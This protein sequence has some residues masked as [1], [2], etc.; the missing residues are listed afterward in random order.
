[1]AIA[2]FA[3]LFAL[4]LFS[5]MLLLLE[6]G[7]RLG[8]RRAAADAEGARAGLGAVEGAVFGLMGLLVAFSF[9][10]AAARFDIR[11]RLIV[12][13]ANAIGTAY[14]RLDLL[15][16]GAQPKLRDQFRRYVDSRLEIYRKLPDVSSASEA[17]VRSNAIQGEI[18]TAA[19]EALREAPQAAVLVLPPLNAMIDITTSRTVALQTHPPALIFAML[20]VVS[21]ACSL[22]A[23]HGMAGAR[24]RS[25]VH[26]VVFAAIL[27]LTVYV[28][29]DLEYPRAGLIRIDAVDKV[30]R[31]VREGMR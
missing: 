6:T 13:E 19:V 28:I 3:P 14:L 5:G 15:P 17:L 7:R 20:G 1:M 16:A 8:L 25:W 11:R 12:E 31:D 23:G 24:S 27:T 22:L 2:L 9:S 10:G 21:L 18:W 30:L 26:I 29:L 4:G